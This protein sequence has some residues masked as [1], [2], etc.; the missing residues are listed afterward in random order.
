MIC[1]SMLL[2]SL[3]LA[4]SSCS[5]PTDNLGSSHENYIFTG[6]WEGEGEDSKG[7]PFKFFSKVSHSGNNRYRMLILAD[8]ESLDEP[9]H[10]MDGVLENNKF[11]L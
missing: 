1:K 5:E 3:C 8:L 4:L 6:N 11:Y 10:I 7:N 9:L 2:L